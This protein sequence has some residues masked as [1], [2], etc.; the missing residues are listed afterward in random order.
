MESKLSLIQMILW[1][2]I[3]LLFGLSPYVDA[4]GKIPTQIKKIDS[5]IKFI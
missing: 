4:A 2:V 3:V 5:K 1:I